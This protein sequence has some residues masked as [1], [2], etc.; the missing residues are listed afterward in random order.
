MQVAVANV[1]AETEIGYSGYFELLSESLAPDGSLNITSPATGDVAIA[2]GEFTLEVSKHQ[3]P[4]L[5]LLP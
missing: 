4:S 3:R 5:L 2:G 1:D